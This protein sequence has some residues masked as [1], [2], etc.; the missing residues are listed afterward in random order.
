MRYNQEASHIPSPI[1][2]ALLECRISAEAREQLKMV[3]DFD[4]L[5]ADFFDDESIVIVLRLSRT[6]GN[7]N[8][9]IIVHG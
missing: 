8:S 4:L 3:D 9:W 2:V 1:D 5:E 6:N 7:L